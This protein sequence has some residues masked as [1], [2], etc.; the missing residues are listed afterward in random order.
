MHKADLHHSSN[1][2]QQKLEAIYRLR[3]TA[4]KVNWDQAGY[5]AL[6]ET[7][8]NP[9]LRIPPV[10]HVAGT[11]GKGSV[12]AFLRSILE[13]DGKNVHVYTSPHLI[14]VNERIVLAG[15]EIE[16][17][18][19]E[20]LIDTVMALND[21]APL[22][23]FEIMTAVAFKAFSEVEAD[24]VLLEV[25]MGGRLDCTNVVVDPLVTIINRISMDHTEFLGQ[26]I[27]D[28][29]MEKAGIMKAGT[30]CVVGYQGDGGRAKAISYTLLS[31]A[32]DVKS[33]ICFYSENYKV[34]QHNGAVHVD[35]NGARYRFPVPSLAGAHQIYNAALA[36][37]S[38]DAVKDRLSVSEQSIIDGVQNARWRGRLQHLDVDGFDL[39]QGVEIWLDC[40]HN[41]SAGAAL[42]VQAQRWAEDDARPLYLVVG[43]LDSKDFNGFLNPLLPFVREM[44]FV[45][46][47][48]D[49]AGSQSFD[50]FGEGVDV[51]LVRHED[52]HAALLS[53]AEIDPC[54]R[55]LICGSVYLAGDVLERFQCIV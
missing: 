14:K 20:A 37:A 50:G 9:H 31:A 55:I 43:M 39:P 48:F 17:D 5:L 54:A 34:S 12:I 21:G 42:A 47:A 22:S 2:L 26:N 7:L 41:D 53:I 27:E 32:R 10:I 4:T 19:L 13:A 3:R 51:K 28:I 33:S 16:D 52:V 46:I 29:A 36:V 45:P 38:L 11:N 30:P 18:Y 1:R 15:Q 23:F 6:L 35:I 49:P 24:V 8:G 25:G 44:H 40:G